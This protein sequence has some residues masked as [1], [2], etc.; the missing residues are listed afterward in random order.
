MNQDNCPLPEKQNLVDGL[1]FYLNVFEF[2]IIVQMFVI[3]LEDG[4]EK[5]KF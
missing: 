5:N 1:I 3:F 2:H 4:A